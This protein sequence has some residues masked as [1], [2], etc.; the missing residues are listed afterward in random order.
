MVAAP[1][2]DHREF[3]TEQH[4]ADLVV[5]GGGL[6]GTCA[7]ITAAR[8]GIRV[9][10]VQDRPVLG[11]NASSEVR[12][13]ALGATAHM[14]NNNR[15][16]R[17]GGVMDEIM[18]ENVY[19]N[20]EGNAVLVD[21]VLLDKVMAEPNITLLLNTA[22]ISVTKD[23]DGDI[24]SVTAF[25]SQNSTRYE[26]S[27]P[28]FCDASGDGVLGFLAGAAFRMG[29]E[30]TDEFGEL[31]APEESY[32]SL[33][34][35]S[36]YFYSKDVGAP[37]EFTPP[38]YALADIT[39]IPR[40]RSFT[41]K[42]QGCRLWWIE[43][44]GRLDTVHD[45]ETIKWELWKVVYGV[46]N[47]LK[48]SGQFPEA[49]TLTLEWVGLIP[50]K[51]ESRRF[52]GLYML[53][54]QDLVEQREHH[55][56]IASGGWSIDLHP[57]D[58]VFSEHPGSHHLHARG[59]Y[60]VPYRSLVSRDIGNLFLAG[61]IISV[62]HVAFAS[63]RV[64]ATCGQIAQA[65]GMA[66]AL[67]TRQGVAPADL[68][69]PARMSELQREL[70]RTGQHIP[71][72]RLDD[73]DDL[74]RHAELSASSSFVLSSLPDDGPAV[75]LDTSLAQLLPVPA[76]RLPQLALSVDV[77]TPTT[78]RVELRSGARPDDYT[79]DVVLGT[80]EFDLEAGPDQ[81]VKIDLDVEIDE[82]R[83]V[84]V[85]LMANDDVAVHTTQTRISGLVSVRHTGTQES[86][87]GI[88]RP[89][90]EF[91]TPERRPGGHNLALTLDPPITAWKVENLANGFARPT[92]Q[93]NAWV[94]AAG[95]DAP[96]VTVRWPA[97]RRIA[98]LDLAF[99]T[100]FD[101]AMETVLWGHPERAMPF[102]VRD[103]RVRAGD[104]VVAERTG[105][106]HTRNTLAFDPPLETDRLTIDI[107][108]THGDAPAAVFE[109]RAYAPAIHP[110][111][112]SS[113]S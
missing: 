62:S 50:G 111:G 16:S 42:V 32:G 26:L 105:N 28:L 2:T 52:E 6:A 100:D 99:D 58:G 94:A 48:N 9:V 84:F 85:A 33:L 86:E 20:P 83:Y 69:E 75:A 73:P 30:S 107:L 98:R 76:G 59:V 82:P 68:V 27:A 81:Q 102:C 15:W 109:V 78:L 1:A 47:H 61:R 21:T 8:A 54:Q 13:W 95:D 44:G 55:D 40:W 66:A 70:L 65:I 53:R 24:A 12:L 80:R 23:G 110:A 5:V 97:P 101:H 79:P 17:E 45:T 49:E 19:R 89:R 35:Q 90:V 104:T 92:A 31:F 36:I 106:H 7:A 88:G 57:A 113:R 56:A 22:A 72:L 51:R 18:V 37:V 3:R 43:Y 29:A 38:D 14:F 112:W 67:C 103:Y 87:P 39:T 34:G 91:W 74:V 41:T 71:R 25:N 63:T 10:L 77:A 64:M 93:P 4:G 108:A 60:Q 96:S 11:G 46:W